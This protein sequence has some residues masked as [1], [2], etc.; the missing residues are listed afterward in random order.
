MTQQS[1]QLT[2]ELTMDHIKKNKILTCNESHIEEQITKIA[3]AS[4]IIYDSVDKTIT[5][6]NSYNETGLLSSISLRMLLN[7]QR[8]LESDTFW[9]FKIASIASFAYSEFSPNSLFHS[10]VL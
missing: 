8:I 1:T 6:L 9:S 2:G 4:Q 5:I 10:V 7:K 3:K